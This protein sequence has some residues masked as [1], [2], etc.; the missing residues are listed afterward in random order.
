[1][2]STS[3]NGNRSELVEDPVYRRSLT[4]ARIILGIWAVALLYT[5]SYSYLFGYASHPANP[6]ATGPSIGAMV[7]R[8]ESFDRAPGSLTTP[9][10]LGI[11]DWIFYGVVAPWIACIVATFVFCLFVFEEADLGNESEDST[12]SSGGNAP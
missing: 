5:C 9:F 10:G 11:P 4:E 2:P 3:D 1:M 6:S 12:I 8:L 7:G